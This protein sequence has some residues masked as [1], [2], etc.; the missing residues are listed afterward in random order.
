MTAPLP[1]ALPQDF[2]RAPLTHRGLHDAR[3]G[4]PE[5]S[6]A[7]LAAAAAAGYGIEF[8]VQ[9][10]ADGQAV[11]FHDSTLDRTTGLSGRVDALTA[12]ELG[13]VRLLDCDETVPTL[14]Q[15]LALVGGRVPLLIEIKDQTNAMAAGD[16]RLEAA[17]A[18]ALEGYDGPV[19]LMSYNPEHIAALARLAPDRPRGLV[20]EAFDPKNYARLPA[21]VCDRLRA[22][23]D[24]DRVAAS[25]ISHDATDLARSR[26]AELKAKGA[27]LLCWTVRS[28]AEEAAARAVAE[29]VT[30]EGYAA[31][32][33]A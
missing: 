26:V 24:Y 17:V 8:D 25:F 2:L 13:K 12:A 33:P 28:P 5:H 7:A 16:G 30:F 18:A 32:I 9:G 23:A 14:P 11:V 20:T 29:N 1:V 21:S 15:L 4:R 31:A 10:T 22:I 27:R 19:A 6:L 3:A